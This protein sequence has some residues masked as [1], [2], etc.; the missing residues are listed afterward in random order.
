MD[1]DN[2]TSTERTDSDLIQRYRQ[3]KQRERE[4]V[5]AMFRE[6]LERER[7]TRANERTPTEEGSVLTFAPQRQDTPPAIER[8]RGIPCTELP[9]ALG[10]TLTREW[11]TY[12]REVGRLLAD[13]QEGRHV[14]I[15]GEEIIG[16]FDTFEE[17]DQTG[18]ESYSPAP[19]FVHQIR[20]V[21]PFLRI[22]G[23]NYPWPNF[24]SR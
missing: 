14:L 6:A 22:R 8:P 16:I 21:E 2:R 9:E 10:G 18:W 24:G 4:L 5:E 13:V 3:R 12:R 1:Q 17:A 11:N 20:A 7:E 19:Y 23:I 15:K